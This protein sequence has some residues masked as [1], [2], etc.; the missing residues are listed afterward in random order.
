VTRLEKKIE[1]RDEKIEK[2]LEAN[3]QQQLINA[4]MLEFLI[5]KGY[6]G[7]LGNAGL[8]SND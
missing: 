2:L 8:S 1:A 4:S 3:R 6:T 7:H 5:E